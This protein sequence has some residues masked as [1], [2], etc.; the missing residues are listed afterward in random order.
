MKSFCDSCAEEKE[1]SEYQIGKETFYWCSDC[2][3]VAV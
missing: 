2:D 3:E 1:V